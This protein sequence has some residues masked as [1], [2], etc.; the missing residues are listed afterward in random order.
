[1]T[2]YRVIPAY[3]IVHASRSAVEN[4]KEVTVLVELQARFDEEA[5]IRWA[6]TLEEVGAH[7]VYGRAGLKT[8]C[9][10]CLVVR[11]ETDGLRRYCHPS[12]RCFHHLLLAPTDL[13]DG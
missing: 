7:V 10:A 9:K 1:M 8:H 11:Q 2:L 13:R 4:G 12:A 6:R 3:P 5:N